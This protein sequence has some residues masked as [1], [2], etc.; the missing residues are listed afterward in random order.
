MSKW[1]LSRKRKKQFKKDTI[2]HGYRFKEPFDGYRRCN[3]EWFYFKQSVTDRNKH[4]YM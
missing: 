3:W 2:H 4:V 1:R